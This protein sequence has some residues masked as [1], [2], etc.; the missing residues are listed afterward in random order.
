MQSLLFGLC[1]FKVPMGTDQ[2]NDGLEHHRLDTSEGRHAHL[3]ILSPLSLKNGKEHWAQWTN[4][5]F[6]STVCYQHILQTVTFSP[7]GLHRH[8]SRVLLV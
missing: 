1:S 8:C 6:K 3:R 7:T 5:Y 2:L 4:N